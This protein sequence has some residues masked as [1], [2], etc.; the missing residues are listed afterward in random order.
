MVQLPD[1]DKMYDM[2]V[3]HAKLAMNGFPCD[4]SETCK[5]EE[6]E[7]QEAMCNETPTWFHRE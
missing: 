6:L 5:R 1:R 4:C 2:V 3:R 7:R